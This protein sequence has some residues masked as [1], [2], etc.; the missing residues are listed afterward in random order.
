MFGFKLTI[1]N[2]VFLQLFVIAALITGN[3]LVV[4]FYDTSLSEIE[5]TVDVVDRNGTYS[6]QIALFS[7]YIV[8][9]KEQY[10]TSLSEIITRFNDNLQVLKNGGI[11]PENGAKINAVPTE[12]VA[13]Y[14]Q[15]METLWNKY[16]EQAKEIAELPL[17]QAD[18]SKN[19]TV[20]DAYT[21]IQKNSAKL[22][23]KNRSL[24]ERYLIY[25][26]RSQSYRDGVLQV[27]YIINII[28]I[29]LMVVYIIYNVIRPISKLNEIDTIVSEGNFERKIDYKRDDELGKVAG[30]INRLF[31]NLQNASDFI[32]SIGEGKLDTAYSVAGDVRNDR[33]GSALLE[34]R[35]K[36]REVAEADHQRNWASEGL[37]K[38][39]EIF[40]TYNQSEDFNY[41]I[42]SNLVKYVE[43][44]QGGL[45]IVN[46]TESD[47]IYLELIAA[48]A[49]EK[50]KYIQKRISKG[51]GL[52]GEVFQEGSTVYMTQV[53]NEYVNI[54]SGL[55]EA[56]PRS[57][58][59]VPLKLNEQI[60]GVVELASF[61]EFEPY[62]IEFVEKLSE[63]IASTFASVKT[64][65]QTQKLLKESTQLTEQM[66][67]QEEEMRQNLE[68]LMATQEE[69]QRK[70]YL[71]EEQKEGLE[72]TL[73]EEQRKIHILELQNETLQKQVDELKQLRKDM[74]EEN[75]L[76]RRQMLQ[77]ANK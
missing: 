61:D 41:I 54:T 8:S 68:E 1:R 64:S 62:K 42:I 77:T 38:F 63:S 30:S 9:G 24:G 21:F 32:S 58:L 7:D 35:D 33:L 66:R 73:V 28:L 14:F 20:T 52:I 5:K 6:Q 71:I 50:R 55:G 29:G 70:N 57:I 47:D 67:S 43:G 26:D 4:L 10:K 19:P 36:M 48:Y 76:L 46:D 49:Y 22:L 56:N 72:K 27:I 53:P 18:K 31:L 44:N 12:L 40:R 23:Q 13:G 51:E 59:L 17:Y 25:F 15:P 11:V 60:Y 45:F 16:S 3:Y 37:A 75:N 69:V 65:S 39:A 34:M 2:S 74:E